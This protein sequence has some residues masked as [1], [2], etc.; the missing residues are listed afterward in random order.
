MRAGRQGPRRAG[1]VAVMVAVAVVVLPGDRPLAPRPSIVRVQGVPV[2][3]DAT[4]DAGTSLGNGFSVVEGSLLLGAVLPSGSAGSFGGVP[5]EDDGWRAMLLM[6]GDA[7]DVFDAYAEQAAAIGLSVVPERPGGMCSVEDGVFRC[8]GVGE[9][10]SFFDRSIQI[11]LWRA[12]L[13]GDRRPLSH[14]LLQYRQAGPN[15]DRESDSADYTG[16]QWNGNPPLPEDWP[17]L[18]D[19]GEP[20]DPDYGGLRVEEGSQLVA[21]PARS[22]ICPPGTTALFHVTGNPA[23]VVSAYVAQLPSDG[24]SLNERRDDGATVFSTGWNAGGDSYGA[25]A[26]VRDGEPT[27]LL[28][29]HCLGD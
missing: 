27:Y 13:E 12:P 22:S 21:H 16:D 20:Y 2:L 11:A 7:R 19:V 5:I 10:G 23:G 8:S 9:A 25:A 24:G 14:L 18:P 6:T 29:D 3:A 1:M 28:I 15:P 4:K 26:F 17:D